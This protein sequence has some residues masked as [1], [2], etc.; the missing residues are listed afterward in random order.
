MSD[1]RIRLTIDSARYTTKPTSDDV[2]HITT[3]MKRNGPDEYT[4]A[5]V[6]R[7]ISEGHTIMCAAYVPHDGKGWGPFVSQ[8]LIALDFDNKL[9]TLDDDGNPVRDEKGRI[10]MRMADRGEALHITPW[11][12]LDRCRH[13]LGLTPF[14]CYP[15]MSDNR[16]EHHRF[17]LIIDMEEDIED[18]QEAR[19]AIAW[20]LTEY[21]EADRMC[22]N[23]SRLSFPSRDGKLYYIEGW[24]A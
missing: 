15:S 12:A 18:E 22:S 8:R 3:R 21:P 20:L 24:R 17:R 19:D 5:D 4:R 23:P 9:P 7:A 6:M 1:E 16:P 2:R 11:R 13:H 10:I 14:A